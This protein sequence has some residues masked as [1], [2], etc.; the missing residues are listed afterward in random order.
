MLPSET[1]KKMQTRKSHSWW[2]D[3]HISPKNSKWLSDSL[4]E[5]D[6]L[7]K[8]ML[9]LIEE[10]GDSFAKKAEM[11][12]QRRP[13]LISHVE[14]FYRMYRALAERYN[15][16]TGELAKNLPSKL[17]SQ[18][19]GNGSE[20][21]SEA[22]SSSSL[23]SS[24]EQTPVHKMKHSKPH[25]RAAGFD[26]FLGSN[27]SSDNLRKGLDEPSSSSDSGSESDSGKVVDSDENSSRLEARIIELQN[28]LREATNKLREY[29]RSSNGEQF[30]MSSITSAM[31][32]QPGVE[33]N[34]FSALE[35]HIGVLQSDIVDSKVEI[36]NLKEAIETAA[37][38]F[39]TEIKQQLDSVSGKFQKE[40]S[41]L[42]AELKTL[43]A[44][45]QVEAKRVSEE[46][47]H[48]EIRILEQEKMIQ[49]LKAMAAQSSDKF[50]QEKS[51]LE[52]KLFMLIESET[53]FQSKL[54]AEKAVLNQSIHEFK[55]KIEMLA[56][57]KHEL[58][59]RVIKLEDDVK[60]Y[61][62]D[63]HLQQLHLEHEKLIEEIDESRK[64][65]IELTIRVRELEE[66]V[67]GQRIL[68]TDGAEGKKE[69]IRQ[70]CFSLDYYRHGY[71]QL[72]QMLQVQSKSSA[73]I[74]T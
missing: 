27:R 2:W 44:E 38:Q 5:M 39:E 56:Q 29:E 13:A 61:K 53:L 6:R 68:I 41:S 21:G 35:K 19:S 37:E 45:L 16:V 49:E 52:S 28:E 64:K 70:L 22:A 23:C 34:D 24:P 48:L 59:A 71:H 51:V 4:E 12:Y 30:D 47:S 20:F 11:Y 74:A 36:K 3:S 65:S 55:L 54:Q 43:I 25:R 50:R 40:K 18:G 9:K 32:N 33:N 58:N 26:F 63:E 69:A 1:M 66:E 67:E 60:L 17:E 46:K 57:D 10:D 73:V 8:Q 62:I 42:E 31:E 72:R 14:D 7:V 15:H